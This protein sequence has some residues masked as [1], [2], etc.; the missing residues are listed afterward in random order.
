MTFGRDGEAT[1]VSSWLRLDAKIVEGHG[2]RAW[3]DFLHAT[4]APCFAVEERRKRAKHRVRLALY[5][6]GPGLNTTFRMA[7]LER[8][9]EAHYFLVTAF[10]VPSVRAEHDA[11]IP[12]GIKGTCPAFCVR[13][14]DFDPFSSSWPPPGRWGPAIQ[15][16]DGETC[17]EHEVDCARL[18]ATAG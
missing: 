9:D 13:Q 16:P 17:C 12:A 14:R 6:L 1:V 10:A 18:T 5:R 4:V 11:V 15:A 3:P 2:D 8:Y 7:V